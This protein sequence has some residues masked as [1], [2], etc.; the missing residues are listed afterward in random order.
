MVN[1]RL[2]RQLLLQRQL[3]LHRLQ[4]LWHEHRCLV[5]LQP[6]ALGATTSLVEL[7][8]DLPLELAALEI[9]VSGHRSLAD[10]AAR[11]EATPLLL[12]RRQPL[13]RQLPSIQTGPVS[14]SKAVYA[15]FGVKPLLS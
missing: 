4:C 9:T 10:A 1:H 6:R 2:Q 7:S 3:H 13:Q 15:T 5:T 8:A 11:K 12:L 14:M